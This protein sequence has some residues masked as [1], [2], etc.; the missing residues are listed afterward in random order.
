[1]E[2]QNKHQNKHQ[3]SD[4]YPVIQN[5]VVESYKQENGDTALSVSDQAFIREICART[6]TATLRVFAEVQKKAGQARA[7]NPEN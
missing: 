2:E 1:M 3:E 6:Y 7:E 4:I 5:A